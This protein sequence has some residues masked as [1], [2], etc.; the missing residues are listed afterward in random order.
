MCGRYAAAARRAGAV[1][2]LLLFAP[3]AFGQMPESGLFVVAKPSLRDPNFQRTVVLV[4]NAPDGATLG[5]IVNRPTERS[6][7]SILPGNPRLA[8][9]TEPLFFGGPVERG[10]LFAVFRAEASPGPSVP[11]VADVHLAL[12]PATV[13]Q[14]LLKP[15]AQVRLFSGYSG[16][17]PGQLAAELRRGDWWVVEADPEMVF[18]SD[19]TTL[20]DELSTRARAVTASLPGSA[21]PLRRVALRSGDLL[22]DHRALLP[23]HPD[24]V[25]RTEAALEQLPRERILDRLLDRPL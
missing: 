22:E 21:R 10:G 6:L 9:F 17:A 12:D 13:E 1:L 20:W 25:L 15:P 8:K 2:G 19:M 4:A 3:L 16:W 7:A 24:R 23:L 11:V 18:R 14:L 5:V